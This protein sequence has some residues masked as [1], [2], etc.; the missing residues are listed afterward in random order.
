MIRHLN[1][2]N[3]GDV[4]LLEAKPEVLLAE[5]IPWSAAYGLSRAES[6][7]GKLVDYKDA[8]VV[9]YRW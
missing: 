6:V 2:S 5:A 3:S 7:K 4:N 1:L 8:V 9:S